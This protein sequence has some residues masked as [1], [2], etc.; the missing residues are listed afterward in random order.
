MKLSIIHNNL[1]RS[2]IHV[3]EGNKSWTLLVSTLYLFCKRQTWKKGATVY[4]IN[5][6][7]TQCVS[8]AN[9]AKTLKNETTE[10]TTR[11][12]EL[13]GTTS[14]KTLIKTEELLVRVFKLF[15]VKTHSKKICKL[16]SP[17]FCKYLL[18]T[19]LVLII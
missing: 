15:F 2:E 16:N 18:L 10:K 14:P 13:S 8:C 11:F 9:S 19:L 1:W 4:W 5:R 3:K 12:P 17:S 7:W 6:S